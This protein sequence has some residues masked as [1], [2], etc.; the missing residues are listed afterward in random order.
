MMDVD[1]TG[2][3]KYALFE[4]FTSPTRFWLT[5]L[6]RSLGDEAVTIVIGRERK[7]YNLHK[8]LL[9][10]AVP[11]FAKAFNGQFAESKDD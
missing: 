11:Y 8:K 2:F 1:F 9:C 4:C 3:A 7:K 6:H 10:N 5:I